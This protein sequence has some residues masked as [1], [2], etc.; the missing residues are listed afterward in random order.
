MEATVR[1][2]DLLGGFWGRNPS[3]ALRTT[4][5]SVGLGTFPV[6]C[7]GGFVRGQT[8]AAKK[9]GA[10]NTCLVATIESLWNPGCK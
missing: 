7:K 4:W 10:P 8:L 9:D 3:I 5:M 2:E 6:Q 1:K